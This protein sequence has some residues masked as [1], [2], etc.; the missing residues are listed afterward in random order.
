[1]PKYQL[2]ANTALEKHRTE[3][4][5]VKISEIGNIE[6]YS[7]AVKLNEEGKAAATIKKIFSCKMPAPGNAFISES[8]KTRILRLS[9]D[10]L[11]LFLNSREFEKVNDH[12]QEFSK[13]FYITEQTDAWSGVKVSGS[14]VFECLER[15]CPINL[16]TKTFPV[17]SFA[18]TS[19]EHLNA[20]IV[21]TKSN[22][23]ELY[24]ASS[25]AKSFLHAIETSAKNI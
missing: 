5:G 4:N 17:N 20:L 15:I 2:K 23:F 6:I 22:E 11:F 7:L 12:F 21:K 10:Q 1:M 18:R 8:Q 24:S 3:I 16:S 9:I 14:R 13:F 19:M 25:S